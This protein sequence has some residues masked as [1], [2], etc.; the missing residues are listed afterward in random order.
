[1]SIQLEKLQ[2]PI[3]RFIPQNNFW[4][5]EIEGMI[6]ILESFPQKYKELLSNVSA[7]DLGKQYRE[8]SFT[9]LQLVHHVAD[10]QM[11]NFM[12]FKSAMTEDF[13]TAYVVDIPKWT[14]TYDNNGPIEDSL[15]LLELVHKRWAILLK[16]MTEKDFNKGYFHPVRQM[17]FDLRQA[18]QLSSWH[19]Q[20]HFEHL[21]IALKQ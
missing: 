3:G 9:I 10:M 15:Q 20:H 13:P 7:Q 2:Y 17:K 11:L 21:K 16:S 6:G 8:G 4:P 1:M 5:Q 19:V 12:R 14:Q 18:L